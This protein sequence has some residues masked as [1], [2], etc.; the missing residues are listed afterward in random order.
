MTTCDNAASGRTEAAGVRVRTGDVRDVPAVL[1]LFDTAVRWLVAQGRTGQWGTEPFSTRPERVRQAHNWA[2]GGGLRIAEVDGEVAGAIVL[3]DAPHYAPPATGPE[4]Y[5]Q[6]F[7]TDRARRGHG[8]GAALLERACAETVAR[9][10]PVLRLDCWGGGDRA[11][12]RYYE[13]AGFTPTE[14]FMVG[15]WEGQVLERRARGT[16]AAT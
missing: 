10:L 12:V 2:S 4:L 14:R 1:A 11:L 13:R 6:A 15:E 8:I 9:G 7:V 5:V 16:G 3:G